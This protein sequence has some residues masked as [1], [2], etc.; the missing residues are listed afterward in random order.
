[1]RKC[2]IPRKQRLL[3]KLAPGRCNMIPKRRQ[4][5]KYY[6]LQYYECVG[7]AI[8]QRLL[9]RFRR[10]MQFRITII[11]KR[12]VMIYRKPTWLENL[13]LYKTVVF[14]LRLNQGLLLTNLV[15]N[16]LT[17]NRFVSP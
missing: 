17:S 3:T 9:T 11:N 16:S 12:M 7:L 15:L 2:G 8:A 10:H 6:G 5:G 13:R 14:S 1:M 4:L